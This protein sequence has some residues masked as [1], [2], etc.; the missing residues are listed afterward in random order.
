MA[1]VGH[2]TEARDAGNARHAARRAQLWLGT[3][4][5]ISAEGTCLKTLE[6]GITAAFGA[7]ER[8][9]RALSLHDHDSELSRVNA[10]A[11]RARVA[12]SDDLRAVLVCALDIAQRSN[13]LFD[14]TVGGQLVALGFLPRPPLANDPVTRH[15]GPHSSTC[16][17]D[18][19]LDRD[20]VRYRWP[21]TL[22]FGGIAKGY[23]V[24][25]AI[26]ALRRKGIEAARVNA[27]GDLRVFGK[28]T[29]PIHVRIGGTQGALVP[30]VALADGA[31]ATSAYGNQRRRINGRW[32]TPLIDPRRHLPLMSTRT[33]SVIAPTCMVADALTKVLSLRGRGGATRLLAHF[34]AAA[35]IFSPAGERWRC[36]RLS[37]RQSSKTDAPAAVFAPIPPV[38]LARRQ[39]S[40]SP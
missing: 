37:A 13:G 39:S 8:V 9:H 40:A 19:D 25:C 32:A 28:D 24:D 6:A 1:D 2:A 10:E 15:S 12:I 14:P 5:D 16:W 20:G 36:T 21:L 30:L 38:S 35:A 29:V 7:I 26:G 11:H 34:D 33:V 27:G 4:V 23:A 18:V 31:V 17:R 22:D 3:L